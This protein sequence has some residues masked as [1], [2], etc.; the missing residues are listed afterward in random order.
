MWAYGTANAWNCLIATPHKYE[1]SIFINLPKSIEI[2]TLYKNRKDVVPFV[3]IINTNCAAHCKTE[4]INPETNLSFYANFGQWVSQLGSLDLVDNSYVSFPNYY[5]YKEQKANN[6][7]I[8]HTERSNCKGE[9]HCSSSN[10]IFPFV[11]ETSAKTA[12]LKIL[13]TNGSF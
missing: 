7:W 13:S 1:Y 5:A 9:L 8:Y 4:L 3:I 2:I 10:M 6:I 11:H 12:P